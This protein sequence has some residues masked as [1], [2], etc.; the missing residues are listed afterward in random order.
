MLKTYSKE[1]E[2]INH[3]NTLQE[4]AI[5]KKN[6]LYNFIREFSLTLNSTSKVG[7]IFEIFEKEERN[8]IQASSVNNYIADN[9]RDQDITQA[10]NI[11][12]MIKSVVHA[13]STTEVSYGNPTGFIYLRQEFAKRNNVDSDIAKLKTISSDIARLMENDID[14]LSNKLEFL[15]Q[16]TDNNSGRLIVE[17]TIIRNS[18]DDI[19]LQ[20]WKNI[21][22]KLPMSVLPQDKFNDIINSQIDNDEKLLQLEDL[23]YETNKDKK[24]TALDAILSN[25]H[26][27]DPNKRSKIDRD[28]DISKIS[29]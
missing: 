25:F 9:I 26:N 6:S 28:V 29:E 12:N 8:L 20:N 18:M 13:M 2:L 22:K 23:L 15:K 17:D 7:K 19:F 1:L 3:F 5:L 24:E 14:R 10:L 11:L 27:L 16:L 21:V 4:T